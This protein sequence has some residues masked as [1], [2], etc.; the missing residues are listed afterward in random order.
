MRQL[1]IIFIGKSTKF[2]TSQLLAISKKYEIVGIVESDPSP[3]KDLSKSRGKKLYLATFVKRVLGK[4]SLKA[5]AQEWKTPY[6]FLSKTGMKELESFVRNIVPD[7]ICVASMS[8]L[9]KRDVFSLP[10]LGTINVH[11]SLLP[12]YRGPYPLL[13][14]VLNMEKTGGVTIYFI[15]D[16]ED[17]GA[18]IRQETFPIESGESYQSIEVKIRNIAS[19]LLIRTLDDLTLGTIKPTPQPL[20]SPTA[21]A[22]RPKPGDPLIDWK[23]PI[24]RIWHFLRGTEGVLNILP[25]PIP[26]LPGQHWHIGDFDRSQHQEKPG[27]LSRDKRGWFLAHKDGKIYL[28]HS[29]DLVKAFK[30]IA[31]RIFD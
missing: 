20:T 29:P 9:L 24:E 13:W 28:K 30:C 4:P 2:S 5:M 21:R 26:W 10:R 16:G 11:P 15:D 1:R 6:F 18:I 14:T 22:R 8:Q 12:K 3:G 31:S 17:S 19:R 23:W 7:V 27:Q 25:S